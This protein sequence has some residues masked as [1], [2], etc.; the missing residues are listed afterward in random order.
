[1]CVEVD[2][3]ISILNMRYS[4]SV[5]VNLK[6]KMRLNKHLM[7]IFGRPLFVTGDVCAD[8]I[9]HWKLLRFRQI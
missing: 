1:M 7:H 8:Y 2:N 9:S 5:Q 6:Q 3:N 4:R